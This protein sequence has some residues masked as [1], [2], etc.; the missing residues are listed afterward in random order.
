MEDASRE[1][2][3]KAP[4]A[5]AEPSIAPVVKLSG[6][7][8]SL[9]PFPRRE[10]EVAAEQLA[11]LLDPARVDLVLGLLPGT[12]KRWFDGNESFRN[13]VLMKH[14]WLAHKREPEIDYARALQPKQILAATL[15][16]EG[17]KTQDEV[18]QEVGVTARTIRNW[19]C[20]PA[21][22]MYVNQV[23]QREAER[24]HLAREAEAATTRARI[25]ELQA[26]ALDEIESIIKGEDA[27]AKPMIV[28]TLIRPLLKE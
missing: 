17:T 26:K 28:Q 13:E 27:K 21:F 16:A 12:T 22:R 2:V 25:H 10:Q 15:L 7:A 20:D 9:F 18:A 23:A 24:H 5:H 14:Q 8:R 11:S 4:E 1:S 3:G 19:N 6:E